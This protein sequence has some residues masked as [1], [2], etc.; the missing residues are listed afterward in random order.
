MWVQLQSAAS[1]GLSGLGKG[2]LR[3]EAAGRCRFVFRGGHDSSPGHGPSNLEGSNS[4]TPHCCTPKQVDLF[5]CWQA[6]WDRCWKTCKARPH[7]PPTP[8]MAPPLVCW[9]RGTALGG[10]GL[11]GNGCSC[12]Q[13][14]CSLACV[15]QTGHGWGAV[16]SRVQGGRVRPSHGQHGPSTPPATPPLHVGGPGLVWARLGNLRGKWNNMLPWV[17]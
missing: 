8:P 15:G 7:C 14:D 5:A 3:V 1:P 2:G 6:S 12:R 9:G 17:V 16:D 10:L 13:A 11:S 4:P